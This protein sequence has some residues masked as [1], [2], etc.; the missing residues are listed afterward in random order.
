MCC[1][2]L[3]PSLLVMDVCPVEVIVTILALFYALQCETTILD[4]KPL[5]GRLW[6]NNE[7]SDVFHMAWEPRLIS[8]SY[9][10]S[11]VEASQTWSFGQSG[12][13]SSQGLVITPVSVS[14]WPCLSFRLA[15]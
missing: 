6:K 7:L 15:L 4:V 14:L 3:T 2:R 9:Q 1:L 11:V 12:L 5:L 13:V 10:K 8:K